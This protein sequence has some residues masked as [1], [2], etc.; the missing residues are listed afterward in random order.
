[1]MWIFLIRYR[2]E[3]CIIRL[4]PQVIGLT[5]GLCRTIQ[6]GQSKRPFEPVVSSVA[7][8]VVA[9]ALDIGQCV[10]EADLDFS[11]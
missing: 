3:R 4:P 7:D 5:S 1:M 11:K 6:A 9:G 2:Q 8:T 10:Q